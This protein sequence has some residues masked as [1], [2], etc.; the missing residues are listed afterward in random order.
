[1]SKKLRSVFI[2]LIGAGLAYWFVSQ[3]EWHIVGTHLKQMRSWPLVGAALMINLTMLARSLR[4]QTLLAPIAQVG[5]HNTF[6]ATSIGFGSIF[7]FGRAGEVVRPIIL[8]LREDVPPSAT[9]ATILIERLFDTMTVAAI[10]AFNLLFFT[11]PVGKA[12]DLP[13]LGTIHTFGVIMSVGV[14]IGIVVLVLI[15][16]KADVLL[17]FLERHSRILPEK[18]ARPLLNLVRHVA[19]GLSVLM[20]AR[21]LVK[22]VFYSL[23]VWVLVAAATWLAAV[24]FNIGF[25]FSHAIFVMGFG[26]VGSVVPT[27][28][29]SAGAFHKAAQQGLMFLGLDQNLAAAIAIVYHLIAFGTPFII[30]MIYLIRD[31]I[32]FGRLR[33]MMTQESATA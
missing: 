24:A 27:P 23:V 16:L 33:E 7:V 15:R 18:L 28:G 8:S 30:G 9:I 20:N 21:E 14:V 26:L 19:D 11:L 31:G 29:G 5:L 17:D 22:V 12:D 32:S 10:F 13:T 1:V 6:A 4:W 3:L 2:L 25:S